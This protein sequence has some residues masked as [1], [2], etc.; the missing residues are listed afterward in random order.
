M[1]IPMR[2]RTTTS[3]FL[4]CLLLV[5]TPLAAAPSDADVFIEPEKAGIDYELQGEY[6]G[7]ID[8]DDSKRIG[9]QGGVCCDAL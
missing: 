1:E 3:S 4:L 9:I 7:T 5:G 8:A 6:V 2:L